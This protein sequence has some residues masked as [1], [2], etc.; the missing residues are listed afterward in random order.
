MKRADPEESTLFASFSKAAT[1]CPAGTPGRVLEA[2]V[3]AGS[4]LV[5]CENG[6]CTLTP[7]APGVVRVQVFP[8]GSAS[9]P[10]S[11]MTVEPQPPDLD[12]ELRDEGGIYLLTADGLRAKICKEP[13]GLT[14][15]AGP[16]APALEQVADGG[17]EWQGRHY[18]LRFRLGDDHLYGLGEPYQLGRDQPLDLRGRSYPIWNHHYPPSRMLIPFVLSSRGYGLFFDNPW[19]A[20]V[21]AGEAFPELLQ[22]E[23]DGGPIRYYVFLGDGA[24]EILDSYTALT[25]RAPMPPIWALGYIQSKFGYH[26]WDEVDEL[27]DTFRGKGIPCDGIALD[28][29]WFKEM[30]DLEFDEENWPHP[31]EKIAELRER[32][33]HLILIE[34]P[35]VTSASPNHA[36]GLAEGVFAMDASGEQYIFRMWKG[37]A[38]LV[39]FSKP[40]ARRW[41]AALHERLIG[42]G[43]G[44]WWTD[45]NEP[46]TDFHD[47]VFAGGPVLGQHNLQPLLMH[48]AV[49]EAQRRFAP[50]MRPFVLSRSAFAGSQRYGAAVWSGDVAPTWDAFASQVVLGQSCSLAGIPL[51]NCDIGGFLGRPSPELYLRWL[52][53]ALFAPICRAHTAHAPREPWQFGANVERAAR[54]AIRTRYSL[55][56]YIYSCLYQTH[57]TGAPLMRPTFALFPDDPALANRGGQYM[58]GEALLVAPVTEPGER[59]RGI[60]LPAG[61]WYDFWTGERLEGGRGTLARAPLERIPVFARAGAIVP[62]IEPTQ[63]V[64][65]CRWEHLILEVYTGADGRFLLYEDDGMTTAYLTGEFAASE[66]VYAESE[67]RLRIAIGAAEG[68]FPGR[69]ERRTYLVKLIGAEEPS[70]VLCD[71]APLRKLDSKMD[72]AA[73]ESGWRYDARRKVLLVSTPPAADGLEVVAL[74][75]RGGEAVHASQ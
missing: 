73:G 46:E 23:A 63:H 16:S 6:F 27:A 57:R 66:I 4:L 47:M 67:D 34:E 53:F 60:Y 21:D 9:Q 75:A 2:V 52:Q 64:L 65:E 18:A 31:A 62:R 38:S 48:R 10:P 51:W 58:F 44:G 3:D 7:V 1:P 15:S 39:D 42:W 26:N 43:I 14:F 74:A 55:L 8:G 37:M 33:F 72:L 17:V 61:T 5:R 24:L 13:F 59:D 11:E 20:C 30:G 40:E 22:Y 54:E 28:L 70:A 19:R 45:L 36:A 29:Y 32:G 69:F 68:D 12:I 50:E 71:G 35:Y 56:P 41:W 49:F 25:G